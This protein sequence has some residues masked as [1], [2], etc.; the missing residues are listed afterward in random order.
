MNRK[1]FLL[2][3]YSIGGQVLLL[4]EL[5]ASFNGDE[6]FIGTALFGWLL[7]VA[8]G[9]WLGGRIKS[10][11]ASIVLFAAGVIILPL[12]I[13]IARLVP[14][15]VTDAVG[16]IVPFTTAAIMSVLVTLPVGFISG[17]LFPSICSEG[18]R[19]SATIGQVYFFEGLGAFLGGV[20]VMAL[21]GPV[22]SGLSMAFGI[23][24]VVIAFSC[25][26]FK[27]RII[28]IQS[29]AVLLILIAIRYLVP[30]L[31]TEID[32]YRYGSFHLLKTFDTHYGRQTLLSG[33][34]ETILLT[35]NTVEAVWPDYETAENL[36]IPPLLYKPEAENILV[37]GRTEMGI[38]QLAESL[39]D[40]KITAV[41]PRYLLTETLDEFY[42]P[43]NN[44]IRIHDDPIAYSADRNIY[45]RYDIIIINQ[46]EPDN[47]KNARYIT[48]RF[49]GTI[50][51]L[52]QKGGLLYLVTE[53]DT[54]RYIS[55]E[56]QKLLSI[57]NSILGYVFRQI[58]IWPG[59]ATA[60]FAS[61]DSLFSTGFDTLMA[62]VEALPYAPRF[63]NANYL[64]DRLNTFKIE[65]VQAAAG[66]EEMVNNLEKPVLVHYQA[67]YRSMTRGADELLIKT[68]INRPY[69]AL[70]LPGGIII[71]IL[72]IIFRRAKRRKYGLFLYLVAGIVSLSMELISFY[73]FQS[74]AGSLYS[75][76]G[77]L[78]GAFMLGLAL[79]TWYSMRLGGEHLEYP[80]LLLL[81][82][83]AVVFLA[84]YDRLST[85]ILPV[86]HGLFLFTI[87][88][89]TGSLFVA[90]T[91][92]YYF[93]RPQANRG[94]GYAFEIVGSSIGA[95]FSVTL[96][97]PLI[98]LTWLIISL[99]LLIAVAL[100]GAYITE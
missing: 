36:L 2:G 9:A 10:I 61:D 57:Y 28:Y 4:R 93:G 100:I 37:I 47:Y 5:T 64:F 62:R 88:I 66:H 53:Y 48:N 31:D 70:I 50:K 8:F 81:L 98:G 45:S 84:T 51:R 44:I 26:S 95:L 76:M 32:K 24:L 6:I 49:M 40:L 99:I 21:V 14:L 22:F 20:I 67:V 86:Y 96:F 78:I 43:D 15:T 54:D 58:Y 41:D 25:F 73:L 72:L 75:Q 7:A 38:M 63:V 42:P 34:D 39:P 46:G 33:N 71:F 12:M 80:S 55:D 17:A 89:A 29:A 11:K 82:T 92:R 69:W 19:P 77:I 97:L 85:S 59:T 94:L 16:E 87:A 3:F 35:D 52:L 27:G 83:A 74:M 68:L 30:Y 65:R 1:A 18:Y 91:I 56:K 79:G 23:G 13:I 60:F 90:A